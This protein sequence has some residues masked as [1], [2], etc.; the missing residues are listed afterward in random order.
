ML[1][2]PQRIVIPKL[3]DVRLTLSGDYHSSELFIFNYSP[4]SL[5]WGSLLEEKWLA[6]ICSG[7]VPG[8]CPWCVRLA[9]RMVSHLVSAL[10]CVRFV[11]ALCLR[12]SKPCLWPPC[13]ASPRFVAL[14]PLW[15]RLQTLSAMCPL[16]PWPCLWILSAFG[17]LCGRAVASSSKILSHHC[18]ARVFILHARLVSFL[19][20]YDGF[21][22]SAFAS[23]PYAWQTVWGLCWYNF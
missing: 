12:A 20:I 23:T 19:G 11:S 7:R 21:P 18:D 8:P 22:N 16:K 15:R 2:L 14:S 6:A 4:N 3:D 17:L 13:V 10:P 5:L 9:S 1:W